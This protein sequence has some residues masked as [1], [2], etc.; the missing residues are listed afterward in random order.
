MSEGRLS[1][2]RPV[3]AFARTDE[4]FAGGDEWERFSAVSAGAVSHWG[5]LLWFRQLPL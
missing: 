4:S 1:R 2:C 3:E 5:S